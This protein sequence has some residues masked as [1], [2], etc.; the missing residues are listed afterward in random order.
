LASPL[1]LLSPKGLYW[2]MS[3]AFIR[4]GSWFSTG[5]KTGIT[6]GFDSGSTLDY[7]YENDARGET[8]LGRMID[9]TFLDAIG[10]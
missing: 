5:L 3:R 4:I 7:V 8:H 9:R 10:W 1:P 2:A 6:T